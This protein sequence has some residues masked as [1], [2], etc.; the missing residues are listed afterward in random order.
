VYLSP[1]TVLLG[2]LKSLA[3]PGLTSGSTF[4]GVAKAC[5]YTVR[6]IRFGSGMG[7]PPGKTRCL[8]AY[9]RYVDRP[10]PVG[11]RPTNVG[12]G[13]FTVGGRDKVL[14]VGKTTARGRVDVALKKRKVRPRLHGGV[15][16]S[17]R[18]GIGAVGRRKARRGRANCGGWSVAGCRRPGGVLR[19]RA[20]SWDRRTVVEEEWR[21]SMP[22]FVNI[23]G[24]GCKSRKDCGGHERRERTSGR[25]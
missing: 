10:T 1:V 11:S 25:S 24:E 13:K 17:I 16:S 21:Q 5:S 3:I 22:N 23:I 19:A 8:R 7:R 20:L 15:M 12:N 6:Q 4:G 9:A 2:Q 14:T 18:V